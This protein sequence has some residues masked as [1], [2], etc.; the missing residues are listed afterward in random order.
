[1]HPVL[2]PLAKSQAAPNEE[3]GEGHIWSVRKS[4]PGISVW[5]WLTTPM[6]RA[7][8]PHALLIERHQQRFFLQ[9]HIGAGMSC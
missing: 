5:C 6:Q 3:C 2:A 1:M 9:H 7:S 8:T 4:S